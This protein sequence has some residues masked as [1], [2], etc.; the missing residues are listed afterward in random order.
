MTTDSL[1]FIATPDAFTTALTESAVHSMRLRNGHWLH[2]ATDS[3][4]LRA[5]S[6][7]LAPGESLCVNGRWFHG[8]QIGADR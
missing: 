5:P 2:R 1:P 4:D 8:P 6:F 7:P 3:A